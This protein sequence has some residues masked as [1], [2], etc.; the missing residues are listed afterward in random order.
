MKCILLAVLLVALAAPVSAENQIAPEAQTSLR[1]TQEGLL[2][3]ADSAG[4]FTLKHPVLVGEKWDDVRKP[5]EKKVSGNTATL[6]FDG[7]TS[8]AVAWQP[9]EGTL[10]Y[11]PVD[12]PAGV[13]SLRVEM[14]IDF[15]YVNGGSW[16]IGPGKETP[17]PGQKPAQ[18]HLFQGNADVL[19]LRNFEGATLAVQAS[20]QGFQQLTDN[21]E[22]DWKVFSWLFNAYCSTG[23]EPLRIKVSVGA[24]SD[25]ATKLVD[26]FGQS[27]R[28][29]FP[30]KVK[31]EEELKQDVQTEAAW[32]ASLHP[33]TLDRFGGLPGSGSKLGLKKS[34]FFHLEKK[35]ERW[36]LVDPEGNAFFHLGVC[37]FGPCDDYTYFAGRERVY[38]WLPAREGEFVSAFHPNSHWNSLALSFHLVNTIR[39]AGKPYDPAAYTA[40]MIERVRKWGFNSAGAFGAGDE[41]VRRQM[42]FP[43]VAH[44]PLSVWD[45]FPEVP[46]T[47]GVF[48]PFSDKVREQCDKVFA[49]ELPPAAND[50]LL[51]GYFLANEPLWEEIPGAIAALDASHPCKR[52]LAR[53]LEEKYKTIEAFNRAWETK[54][55]TFADVAARGLP[56]TT[57]SAKEDMQTFT[58]IFLDAYFRLVTETFHKYDKNHLLIGNRFQPGTI[59]N[60]TVCRLSGQ[61]MDLVSFNYYAYGFD[62]DLLK[63]IRSWMGD[64]PMFFSEFYFS[65]PPDSGLT[66]GGKDLSSQ[67]ARGLAYRH[68]VEHA[69]ALGYVV[70]I[71][72]FTL[73]DQATSGRFFEKY[74]GE[75]ANTGLISVADRPWKPMIEEML[76]TNYEIYKVFF[77]ERPPFVFDD[78]RFGAK[79]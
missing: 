69:A 60:E 2:I 35:G 33:L 6:Q 40:R 52:R 42:N 62:A 78:P 16:Q 17:F 37:A 25:K 51:I 79:R 67:Q 32:L 55:E 47:H 73:V 39:K 8:I 15:S 75:A 30:A 57:F 65:S 13:K 4:Q 38:E 45:G 71:E 27:T 77:G 43:H 61:Y 14:L 44:L 68:Y 59:N 72:W 26:R 53:M 50:P 34:G 18:P 56:I 24:P 41:G 21:R 49:K 36:I 22:W 29:D 23:T 64:K 20:A 12:V 70:G 28:S 48:D 66:G 1:L 10:T 7:S 19:K 54:M 74:N 5:I 9:A 11:T 76:K 46:G 58:G 3:E 31:T 63:R